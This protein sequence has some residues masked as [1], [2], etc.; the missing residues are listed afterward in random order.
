MRRSTEYTVWCL[1][2]VCLSKQHFAAEAGD[3][4]EQRHD[5]QKNICG[6]VYEDVAGCEFIGQTNGELGATAAP[7]SYSSRCM[8]H[9]ER[10][11]FASAQNS[12]AETRRHIHGQDFHVSC[13][14]LLFSPSRRSRPRTWTN[15]LR[16]STWTTP[17]DDRASAL[18]LWGLRVE[19][20]PFRSSGNR[21]GRTLEFHPLL[22]CMW[23]ITQIMSNPLRSSKASSTRCNQEVC[24]RAGADGHQRH[25]V[26]RV[27]SSS[28]ETRLKN[29]T[30][31]ESRELHKAGMICQSMRAVGCTKSNE[32]QL[33]A[34]A[35]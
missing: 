12:S 7:H 28:P 20:R 35:L 23:V 25:I 2:R 6:I 33:A 8:H 29:S 18:G 4:G 15:P 19:K 26:W 17:N 27:H 10:V 3:G 5:F 22:R 32:R 13:D 14:S 21:G 24:R 31:R 11:G 34:R 16:A 1:A 30:R 9:T